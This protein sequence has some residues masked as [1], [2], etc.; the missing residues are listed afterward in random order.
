MSVT[1]IEALQNA[2]I[3]LGLNAQGFQRMLGLNQLKNGIA[4][5]EKGYPPNTKVEPLLEAHADIGQVPD[6]V[7]T[8]QPSP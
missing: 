8:T 2:E 6:Y 4:L 7:P 1:I 5:L 3:N